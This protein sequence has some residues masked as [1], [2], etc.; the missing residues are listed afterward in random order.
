[1]SDDHIFT[2]IARQHGF[3]ADKA[4]AALAAML[5]HLRAQGHVVHT[6]YFIYRTGSQPGE[7][8]ARPAAAIRTRSLLVFVTPDT[9]LAFAQRN[10]LLPTPRL[11]RL[12]ITQLLA[13]L[14]QHPAIQTLV[15][16]AEPQEHETLPV[17]R[18]PDG[19]RLERTLLLRMLKGE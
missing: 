18:L 6:T 19:L 17:G 2:D 16:V 10:N 3:D 9:A 7:G 1:M 13:I 11:S 5:A 14:V 12:S 15:F 8:D 4:H